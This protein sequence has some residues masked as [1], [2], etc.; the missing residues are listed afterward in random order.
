MRFHW[1]KLRATCHATE[2]PERVRHAMQFLSGLDLQAFE[3]VTEATRIDSHHGGEVWS[4]ETTLSRA[5]DIRRALAPL[6]AATPGLAGELE[7]RTDDDGV[8]YLRFDKQEAVLGR[9]LATRGEG[10]QVRLKPEVHPAGRERVVAALAAW[11][12]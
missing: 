12:G 11:L 10:V 3:G 4:F 1:L 6:R 2:E 9:V 7:A 5:G 8:L